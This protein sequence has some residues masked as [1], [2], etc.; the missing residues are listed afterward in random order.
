MNIRQKQE[1]TEL[2]L[3]SPYATRSMDTKGRRKPEME[4]EIRTCF[5]RDRDRI[6]HCKAFRRLKDKTQVFLSPVGDHYRTRLM[7]TLEVS[8]NARTI[9]KAL[10]LNGS[11]RLGT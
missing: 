2:R 3:L 1:Q 10:V 4:C 7:H 5:Q 8:Q 11:A 6:L 9:A